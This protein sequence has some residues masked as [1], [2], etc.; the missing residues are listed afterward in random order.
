MDFIWLSAQFWDGLWVRS[1]WFAHEI[2]ALGHRVLFVEPNLSVLAPISDSATR[3]YVGKWTLGL[4][5]V[6]PRVWVVSP[7]PLF[8]FH[9]RSLFINQVN[10]Y[11]V[12][13][14]V[15]HFIRSLGLRTQLVWVSAPRAVSVLE[16]LNP[17]FVIYDCRDKHTAYPEEANRATMVARFEQKLIEQADLVLFSAREL[18][19]DHPGLEKSILVPPG[20]NIDLYTSALDPRL[21]PPPEAGSWSHLVVMY[22]G[23]L[24]TWLDWDLVCCL[25]ESKPEWTIVLVGPVGARASAELDRLPANVRV[26]GR[27]SLKEL[28]RYL[29]VASVCV[30]P[31]QTNELTRYVNPLKLYEYLAAGKPVVSSPLPEVQRFAEPGIVEIAHSAVEFQDRIE[32]LAQNDNEELCRRRTWIAEQHSWTNRVQMILEAIVARCRALPNHRLYG[33]LG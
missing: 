31:F 20:V 1:Q 22:I 6:E 19:Q 5:H 4:R 23:A 24:D 17:D 30:I 28:P 10:G 8:P 12:S 27:R 14:G 9:H 18:Q 21:A 2:G 33:K 32:H 16:H 13:V 7:P 26:I 25:A 29:R 15:R 3:P 11:M